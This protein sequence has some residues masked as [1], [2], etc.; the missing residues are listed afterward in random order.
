VKQLQSRVVFWVARSTFM[1]LQSPPTYVAGQPRKTEEIGQRCVVSLFIV[2]PCVDAQ[3]ISLRIN[4]W[5]V[6]KENI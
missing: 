1:D 2:A 4:S 6:P 3:P 5:A